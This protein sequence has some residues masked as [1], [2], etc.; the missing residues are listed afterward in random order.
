M[1]Y[2][3]YDLIDYHVFKI[4]EDTSIWKFEDKRSSFYVCLYLLKLNTCISMKTKARIQSLIINLPTILTYNLF[5][6]YNWRIKL[7]FYFKIDV[8]DK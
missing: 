5:S 7:M 4:K 3:L 1:K 2:T 8:L 6:N